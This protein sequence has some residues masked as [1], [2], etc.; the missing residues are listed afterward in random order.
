[1]SSLV[2]A[3]FGRLLAAVAILGLLTP[4]EAIPCQCEHT[5]GAAATTAA[6][7]PQSTVRSEVRCC[8]CAE[9]KSDEHP[10]EPGH[11]SGKP[12][13]CPPTCPAASAAGK[14]PVPTVAPEFYSVDVTVAGFVH[15]DTLT[16]PANGSIAA[17]F[18]PPKL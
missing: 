3:H 6:A 18:H 4:H 5:R 1:M 13:Q 17:I 16:R 8:C 7:A 9:S 14:L 11:D 15:D 10:P 2:C 12:C